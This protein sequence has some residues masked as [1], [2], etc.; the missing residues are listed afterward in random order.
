MRRVTATL[1]VLIF[2][3]VPVFCLGQQS[4]QT[5]NVTA[6]GDTVNQSQP[7]MGGGG[8][9]GGGTMM[10]GGGM[11]GQQTCPKC[12]KLRIIPTDD[13][14]IVVVLDNNKLRKYDRDLNI[15][16]EVIVQDQQEAK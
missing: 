9:M 3:L 13:G 2:A 6:P 16:N 5:P 1:A 4:E 8:M 14:G 11:M 7:T 10:G 12:E 15:K